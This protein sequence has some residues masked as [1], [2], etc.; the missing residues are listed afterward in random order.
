M[1]F[2]KPSAVYCADAS[3]IKSVVNCL[4]GFAFPI[5]FSQTVLGVIFL[6]LVILVMVILVPNQILPA[7]ALIY[8]S[9]HLKQALALLW[10][11]SRTVC[12]MVCLDIQNVVRAAVYVCITTWKAARSRYLASSDCVTRGLKKQFQREGN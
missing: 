7:C 11:S 1:F 3:D 12:G 8:S 2:I 4:K 6:K 5:E 10:C 9:Y